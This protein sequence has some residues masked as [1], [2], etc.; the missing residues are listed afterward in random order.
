MNYLSYS[1]Y[2]N[3]KRGINGHWLAFD[4]TNATAI[5]CVAIDAITYPYLTTKAIK[6]ASQRNRK[7]KVCTI[8]SI[9]DDLQVIK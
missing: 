8:V 7:I 4:Q 5:A 2:L 3:L 9:G 6:Y 1:D